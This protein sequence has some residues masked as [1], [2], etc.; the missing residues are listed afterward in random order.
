MAS[1]ESKKSKN[2]R[3]RTPKENAPSSSK[4]KAQFTK[5]V[6][7]IELFLAEEIRRMKEIVTFVE[8]NKSKLTEAEGKKLDDEYNALGNRILNFVLWGTKRR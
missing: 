3:S 1:N 4:P 5:D 8:K 7:G 6:S 2:G